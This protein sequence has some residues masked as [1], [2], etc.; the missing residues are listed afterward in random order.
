MLVI[1]TLVIIAEIQKHLRCPSRDELIKKILR[2]DRKL[3]CY[4]AIKMDKLP[5]A[6]KIIN[7]NGMRQVKQINFLISLKVE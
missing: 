3:L 7:G 6:V 4:S 1:M 5:F 2:N